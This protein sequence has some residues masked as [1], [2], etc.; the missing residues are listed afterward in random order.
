MYLFLDRRLHK[1]STE[2]LLTLFGLQMNKLEEEK[3]EKKSDQLK[4]FENFTFV[5]ILKVFFLV[6]F[7][8]YTL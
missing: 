4:N 3:R 2:T 5:K 7:R 8:L 1:L 6:I